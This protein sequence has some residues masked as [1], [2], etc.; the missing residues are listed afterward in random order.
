MARPYAVPMPALPSGTRIV[1]LG[2][3]LTPR[4]AFLLLF[5]WLIAHVALGTAIW[6]ASTGAETVWYHL[7]RWLTAIQDSD[8]WK[9][10]EIATTRA[11]S[12]PTG[13]YQ[14]V[15]FTGGVKFQYPLTVITL[16]GSAGR[17]LL[18][19]LTW[20]ATALTAVASAVLLLTALA[21]PAPTDA[22]S[23]FRNP[24]APTRRSRRSRSWLE[25]ESSAS[26]VPSAL[27]S[28]ETPSTSR[29]SCVAI[30]CLAAVGVL[31]FYPV[32]KAYSLGQV[33]SLVTALFAAALLAWQ[34]K[35]HG[36]AG[37]AIGLA[38]LIKPS[39]APLLVWGCVRR[40]WRFVTAAAAVALAGVVT[41]LWQFPLREQLDYLRVLAFIGQRGE[42]FHANQS[43]NGLVNRMVAGGGSL[44]WHPALFAPYDPLVAT[45]T[46]VTFMGLVLLA[47]AGVGRNG[48]RTTLDLA[49]ATLAC[50]AAAPVAWEHH[51]GVLAPAVAATWPSVAAAQPIGRGSQPLLGVAMLVAANYFQFTNH[52]DGTPF[53]PLQSYLFLSALLVL[54]LLVGATRAEH[55]S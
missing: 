42:I 8:S 3:V 15:F 10:I 38:L 24:S 13:I 22:K 21:I 27:A 40:E 6:I 51:Y 43:L 35:R 44:E 36:L 9:P 55:A 39:Y 31:T 41:S 12:G 14:D 17:P 54:G 48:R 29:Q 26:S 46:T 52:F 47:L 50:T 16:F 5:L 45:A 30:G 33:Q 25:K 20:I 11:A 53:S 1:W 2:S 7:G 49:I 37:A 19:V 23:W 4:R 18:N 34:R 32:L 28:F